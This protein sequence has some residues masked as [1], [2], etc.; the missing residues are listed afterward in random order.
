MRKMATIAILLVAAALLGC[1][2]QKDNP[3]KTT[4]NSLKEGSD[5]CKAG[6]NITSVGPAGN[7]TLFEIK[8]ITNHN[9]VQLCEADFDNNGTLV[10]Y[11][12]KDRSYNIMRIK[13]ENGTQEIDVNRVKK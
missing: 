4:M 9:G 13:I 8:G 6:T 10:Q 3:E 1:V 2:G 12:N 11:F 7:Q 5:W